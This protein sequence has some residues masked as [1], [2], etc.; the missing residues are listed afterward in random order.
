MPN[1]LLPLL[2]AGLDELN[3]LLKM[4]QKQ[5]LL[6]YVCLLDKWN[7]TYNLTA[8]RNPKEMVVQHILDSLSVWSFLSGK[9]LI[10]LG[11]GAGLPGIPLA[12]IYPEK[13]F[14]LI[15]SLQKRT[16]FLSQVVSCLGLKNVSIINSKIKEYHPDQGFDQ[17]L[18]RAV[19]KSKQI[20]DDS[21]HLCK[22]GGKWVLLKGQDPTD[23]CQN[24][25]ES[26]ELLSIEPIVVPELN[27]TRHVV[28][29]KN[30]TIH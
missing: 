23:E 11:S 26:T 4:D 21:I 5:R 12:I 7:K 9:R 8:V 16:R 24:L 14:V 6:E 27:K 1:D 20:V 25:P 28:I 3:L 30:N 29:I 19:A 10:D 22:P 13:S 15:D 17:L 2:E 18:A